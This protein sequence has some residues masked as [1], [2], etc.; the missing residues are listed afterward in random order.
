MASGG[1]AS[2]NSNIIKTELEN[3]QVVP[4]EMATSI[5]ISLVER[6][7]PGVTAERYDHEQVMPIIGPAVS[8][9]ITELS[10]N[11]R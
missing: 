10:I 3:I 4:I 11:Q 9:M 7:W 2:N 6:R 5:I 1:A 8:A